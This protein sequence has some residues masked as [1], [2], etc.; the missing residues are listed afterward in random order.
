[1]LIVY[2]HYVLDVLA[3]F[4]ADFIGLLIAYIHDAAR[5]F[6]FSSASLI[7]SYANLTSTTRQLL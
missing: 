2:V 7:W 4:V 1:V 6:T 3:F 5:H